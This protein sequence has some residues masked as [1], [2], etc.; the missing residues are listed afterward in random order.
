MG[1]IISVQC[2]WQVLRIN[3]AYTEIQLYKKKKPQCKV[4]MWYFTLPL[5]PKPTINTVIYLCIK[6][7][8]R[9]LPLTCEPAPA[10]SQHLVLLSGYFFHLSAQ[11]WLASAEPGPH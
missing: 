8:N 1:A 3:P 5:S 7:K 11:R 6:S 2:V 9:L 4:R 10:L